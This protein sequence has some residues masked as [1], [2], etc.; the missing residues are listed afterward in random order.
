ME[1]VM[2]M[3]ILINKEFEKIIDKL[4]LSKAE[5]DNPLNYLKLIFNRK[6]LLNKYTDEEIDVINKN[7]IQLK[8]INLGI[9]NLLNKI[10][11]IQIEINNEFKK[12][13]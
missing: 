3:K 13:R 12:K 5:I 10:D 6:D 1:Y 11:E 9:K 2:S 4:Y 8:E 7:I